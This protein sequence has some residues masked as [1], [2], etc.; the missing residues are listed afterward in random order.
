[1][2]RGGAMTFQKMLAIG[3]TGEGIIAQWMKRQGF[4]VLPV[5]EKEQGEYKGPALYTV[6]GSLIAP[7]M[8]VFKPGGKTVWIEAKTKSAFTM[9]HKTGHWTTGIDLR[10]YQDYLQVQD[11]SPWP[12]WLLFLHFDGQAKDS[13]AGCPTGLFGNSLTFLRQNEHHRHPNGGRGGMVYWQD[14]ALRKI[15]ELS[16]VLPGVY[17]NVPA[18]NQTQLAY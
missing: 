14:T 4:N 6:E 7:D 8:L 3:K 15:A 13:P 12:V 5:Y 11:V 1:M 17:A 16:D 9:H 10:N 2:V 18:Y